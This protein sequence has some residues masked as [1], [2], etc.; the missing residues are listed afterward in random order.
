MRITNPLLFTENHRFVVYRDFSFGPLE[1]KMMACVYQPLVGAMATG[2][3]YQLCQQLPA[4]RVGY[5]GLDQQRKLFLALGL[6]MNDKGRRRLA[7]CSSLLEAVGLLGC[8][9]IELAEREEQIYEYRLMAPLAPSEFFRTQHLVLLLRDK[10]GRF[11]VRALADELMAAAPEELSDP[12]AIREDLTVPFYEIFVLNTKAEEPVP[13]Q[14]VAPPAYGSAGEAGPASPYRFQYEDI[15]ARF[16][17]HS[18]N[19]P[20][21]E[22]LREREDDLVVINYISDKYR[23]TL[24]EICLLLDED[25]VFDLSGNLLRDQLEARANAVFMQTVKREEERNWALVGQAAEAQREMAAGAESPAADLAGPQFE[26]PE[27][28][29]GQY[30]KSEYNRLLAGQPYTRVLRVLIT[31]NVSQATLNLFSKLNLY[32][33]LPDPVLNALIHYMRVMDKP[34]KEKY[35]EK[36]AASLQGQGIDTYGKAVAYFLKEQE[37]AKALASGAGKQAAG[38]M[39]GPRTRTARRP[40]LPIHDSQGLSEPLTPEEEA[41]LERI[42]RLLE[43]Q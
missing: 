26:V 10:L 37:A 39:S 28:L 22:Q 36:V 18:L 29:A 40:N 34:W 8:G 7:E 5:S 13:L 41:E 9:R 19:R 33:K 30:G 3:Y 38:R 17:R 14:P 42:V 4:D 23:L 31:D 25:G 43:R 11:A 35:I 32:Y 6:E 12:Y 21:V 16:P 27:W 15:I 24:K 20:W 1:Q 2:L